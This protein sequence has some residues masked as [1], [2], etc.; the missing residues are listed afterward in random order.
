MGGGVAVNATMPQSLRDFRRICC[1]ARIHLCLT[2]FS[3]QRSEKWR[4]TNPLGFGM[5][6]TELDKSHGAFQPC[7]DEGVQP[8][9]FLHTYTLYSH[10]AGCAAMHATLAREKHA[11]VCQ[12]GTSM[13]S[14]AMQT[15]EF[16]RA[17]A[18]GFQGG[19]AFT[20]L[21][22][23]VGLAGRQKCPDSWFCHQSKHK[24]KCGNR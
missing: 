3:F 8:G 14:K 11:S 23:A 5:A 19:R 22:G 7:V 21:W 16:S 24:Q 17:Q 1:E 12:E 18:G 20:D 2:I 6:W 15:R 4:A 9:P 10:W 13:L